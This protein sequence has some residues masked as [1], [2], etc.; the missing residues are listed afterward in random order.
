MT[1]D[2]VRPIAWLG[3]SKKNL[4]EF[5]QKVRSSI[6]SALF[7]AQCGQMAEHVKPFKA[8][9]SGVFEIVSCYNKDAYR[10]VYGVQI[11]KKIYVLHAFQKKSKHGIATTKQDVDLIKQ[12]YKEALEDA[13]NEQ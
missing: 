11:G 13:K 2:V 4:K 9:G 5:P 7:A 6:G 3:D 10:L 8:V 1:V 12:R